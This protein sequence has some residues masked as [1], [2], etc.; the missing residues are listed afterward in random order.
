MDA[1]L[2]ALLKKT[3]GSIVPGYSYK[4]G[5]ASTDDLPDDAENGDLYTVGTAQYVW[6]GTSW[7]EIGGA[8]ST[9]QIDA[10]F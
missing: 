8:I 9:A 6:N 3:V 1:V 10:L 2:Y 4:G 5:V 7:A